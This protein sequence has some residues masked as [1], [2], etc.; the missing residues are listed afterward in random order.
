[1]SFHCYAVVPAAGSSQRMGQ[2]KLLL[3]WNDVTLIEQ[4]LAE[5]RNSRVDRIVVVVR[6]SDRRLA[7]A[8]Q[9]TGVEVVFPKA[10]P[11]DMKASVQCG[12]R[13][14]ESRYS[15]T[16]SDVWMLAPADMPRLT[17]ADIDIVLRAHDPRDPA[18]LVPVVGGQ[19]GHPVLFPWAASRDVF[20]LGD[21]VGIN[22]IL[23]THATRKVPLTN[24]GCL[25]DVDT[26]QDYV[27]ATLRA[28]ETGGTT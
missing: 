12:L 21:D 7:V 5:W 18:I 14:F 23:K 20:A 24:P 28:K 16:D 2:H 27:D 17:W 1:M 26:P 11:R 13:H 9:R 22:S 3:P 6:K 15:V 19:S 8:C 4:V 25:I 10:D